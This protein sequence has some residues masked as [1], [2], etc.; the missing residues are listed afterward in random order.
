ML[1]KTDDAGLSAPASKAG[2]LQRA[3]LALLKQHERDGAISTNGRFLFYELEQQG[4]IPKAYL[5]ASG[6]KKA[7]QPAQDISDALTV[8]RELG[9]VPWDWILD[10]TRDVADW[11]FAVS[12][13][14]FVADSV[15]YARIDCW[16]GQPAPLIICE[17]RATK[18]VLERIAGEYLCPITAT[19]GQSAGHIVNSIVPLLTGNERDVLYIGDC[20]VGGPADQ[21]EAN[22]RR[23]IEQHAGRIFTAETW[24]RVALTI[25]QVNRR[26]SL[27]RL[28]IDKLDRRC[29]PPRPYKA[30]ECEAVGQV[31]LERMLRDRLAAL[32]PEP[33]ADVQ[34]REERQRAKVRAAL[35]KLARGAR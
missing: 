20:E 18:G 1:K 28:T 6:R 7:R 33:L 26:P 32:L 11:R 22:T 17:S 15:E 9:L 21:I 34:V 29:K 14:K 30:I 13:Y 25:E 16:G 3:C 24:T 31:V 5:D 23:R 4:V 19:G 27:R 12:V 35:A 2:K 8:L 10:E